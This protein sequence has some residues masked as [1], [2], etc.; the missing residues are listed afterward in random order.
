MNYFIYAWAN[1]FDYKGRAGRKE[2][3]WFILISFLIS[4]SIGWLEKAV[5]GLPVGEGYFNIFYKIVTLCPLT[6]LIIRRLHDSNKSGWWQLILWI[7]LILFVVL[8]QHVSLSKGIA[9]VKNLGLFWIP[10]GLYCIVFIYYAVALLCKAGDE[11]ENRFGKPPEIEMPDNR[12]LAVSFVNRLKAYAA[13][14][15]D[16]LKQL[17]Y[18]DN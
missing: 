16:R 2:F 11:S 17:L 8:L 5:F 12:Q 14:L 6:T 7:S 9:P 3:A 18:P 4:W 10:L 1:A 15:F 13:V